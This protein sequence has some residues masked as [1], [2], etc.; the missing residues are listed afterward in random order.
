MGVPVADTAFLQRVDEGEKRGKILELPE[1]S[2][3]DQP[4][5]RHQSE[6]MANIREN[7]WESG[8][9]RLPTGSG[10]TRIALEC[11]AER[12][13][14]N[15]N[16]RILWVSYPT[17]LIEQSMVRVAELGGLY[18]AGTRMLWYDSDWERERDLFE[19]ADIVFMTRGHL[20]SV[21][22][23]AADG[24]VQRNPLL[25]LFDEGEDE[26][27]LSLTMIYD[28]C[29]QL[30]A[31]KLQQNWCA[32]SDRVFDG[33]PHESRRFRV[34]GLSAT[35]LPTDPSSRALL[36]EQ[37]F[38]I[39]EGTDSARPD[40]EMLVHHDITNDRLVEQEILCPVNPYYQERG[41]FEVPGELV[42]EASDESGVAEP[43]SESPTPR[44]INEFVEQFNAEVMS[45]DPIL[46]FLADRLA[47]NLEKLGKTLV[48]V[49]TIEAA[50]KFTGKL[51]NRDAI[52][53]G[54]VSVV[55]SRLD[56]TFAEDAGPEA[57]DPRTQI[58]EFVDRGREPC[59]MV[60]VGMLTTGFDDPKIRTVMLARLTFSTN[61]FWQMIGRGTRGL[62]LGGTQ[63]C[64]VV[65]P[66]RLTQ[67]YQVYEGYRP[68][69]T[70]GYSKYDQKA[71]QVGEGRLDPEVPT[72]RGGPGSLDP[73]T[74]EIDPQLEETDPEWYD[75]VVEALRSFVGVE[76]FKSLLEV[77]VRPDGTIDRMPEEEPEDS[78]RRRENSVTACNHLID[79][80]EEELEAARDGDVDLSWLRKERY[81]PQKLT[82][83]K[84]ELFHKKVQVVVE[85]ELVTEQ[86]FERYTL[87]QL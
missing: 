31:D 74:N 5:F 56:E 84:V 1:N 54:R 39:R 6:A 32:F 83:T 10:K 66:V 70:G 24:R 20:R 71:G 79:K 38:P 2:E 18:P 52:G 30:G 7:G 51:K 86:K 15:V 28:E 47:E 42:R 46:D 58:E 85:H 17:N 53:P 76:E 26:A 45:S 9:L 63:D 35:P 57:T 50:N 55:H 21:L 4:L 73:E 3:R 60:N 33:E 61:L 16:E 67:K 13:E 14:R 87:V 12:M 65:D 72:R 49:P 37:L 19:R 25:R 11:M 8:I 80:A 62:E 77:D 23:D 75:D 68:E 81:F 82:D 34:F 36:R 40:W 43:P 78:R 22:G 27:R 44:E 69:V 64:F 29:H 41:D 48:F 59:I